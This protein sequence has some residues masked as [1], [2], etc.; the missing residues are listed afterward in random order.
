MKRATYLILG[1]AL[2]AAALYSWRLENP[3]ASLKAQAGSKQVGRVD[4]RPSVF[5]KT[6]SENTTEEEIDNSFRALIT[7]GDIN[8]RDSEGRT[9]LMVVS[10]KRDE[11]SLEALIRAGADINLVDHSGQ[12]VLMSAI[13]GGATAVA[14]RLLELGINAK[15]IDHSGQSALSYALGLGDVDVIKELLVRGADPNLVAN[16][17]GYTMAMDLAHEGQ[18]EALKLFIDHGARIEGADSEGNTL[19]HHAVLSGNLQVVE[20]VI[21][22]GAPRGERN[23]AGQT[24]LDLARK[25]DLSQIVEVL[26]R[27]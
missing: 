19:T 11:R 22:S 5:A 13:N 17:A 8:A 10:F 26:L 9:A 3:P 27:P 1:G 2:T 6:P 16:E 20:L 14:M 18:L 12:D 4:S 15:R 24:P 23:K 7:S 21:R 25:F